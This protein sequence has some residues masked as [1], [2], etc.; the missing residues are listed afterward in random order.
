[1]IS[2]KKEVSVR[3][4]LARGVGVGEIH[5]RTGVSALT[6]RT[7]REYPSLRSR[8]DPPSR[9]RKLRKKR[10]CPVCGGMVILWPCVLCSP[11]E[12]DEEEERSVR[13]A[14]RLMPEIKRVIVDLRRYHKEMSSMDPVIEDISKRASAIYD[15]LPGGQPR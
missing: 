10:R 3:K 11:E 13:A 5:R 14:D 4:L 7:I 12:V 1:M 9:F 8:P 15:K 2:I 6:I